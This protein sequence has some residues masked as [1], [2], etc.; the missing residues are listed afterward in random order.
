MYPLEGRLNQW[1]LDKLE[2]LLNHYGQ[3]KDAHDGPRDPL[4]DSDAARGEFLMF[5]RLVSQNRG[6]E[7]P[8]GELHVF[9]AEELFTAIF[10]GASRPNRRIFRGKYMI[11]YKYMHA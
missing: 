3:R 7:K 4:V 2:V 10:G 8:D 1:G 6:R 5:K 9:R 11:K